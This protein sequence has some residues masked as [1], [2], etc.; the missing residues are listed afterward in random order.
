MMMLPIGNNAKRKTQNAQRTT[1]NAF[2][3][4]E[5][6]ISVAILSVGLAVVLS[7]L[8]GLLNTLRISQNTLDSTL[9]LGQ[10]MAELEL[11]RAEEGK[12]EQGF[13]EDFEVDK[14]E[15][16]WDIEL[17]SIEDF[18]NLKKMVA[19]LSWQEGKR[20]GKIKVPAYLRT[21]LENKE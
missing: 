7:G 12:L 19:I 17:T 15:F 10:K 6:I 16:Q 1:N 8:T 5:L 13:S 4:V 18:E 21:N 11:A 9:V 14:L 2:T 20:E 3:L